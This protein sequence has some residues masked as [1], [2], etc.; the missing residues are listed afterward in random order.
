LFCSAIV[1]ALRNS[2]KHDR[3]LKCSSLQLLL[4]RAAY[5]VSDTACFLCCER[6]PDQASMFC[7]PVQSFVFVSCSGQFLQT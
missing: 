3:L 2:L 1:H 5:A 6:R 4:L 7:S